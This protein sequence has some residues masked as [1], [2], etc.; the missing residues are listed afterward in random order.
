MPSTGYIVAAIA[1]AAA[2]TVALRAAPFALPPNM[3][4]APVTVFLRRAMPA[5]AVLILAVY[6]LMAIDLS[7]PR[8]GVPEMVGAAV[9]IGVHLWRR[10]LLLSL[11]AGT[12][13]CVLLSSVG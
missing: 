3:R 2:V 7:G 13:A 1:V 8:N 12:A 5:G 10:N 4:N 11:V 6:C 9:T